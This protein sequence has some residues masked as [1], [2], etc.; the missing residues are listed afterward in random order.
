MEAQK[1]ALSNDVLSKIFNS[2][3]HPVAPKMYP[4]FQG[5]TVSPSYGCVLFAMSLNLHFL[6]AFRKHKVSCRNLVALTIAMVG[7]GLH[8][9]NAVVTLRPEYLS[10]FR[11]LQGLNPIPSGPYNNSK[12]EVYLWRNKFYVHSAARI[13]QNG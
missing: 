8:T 4:A 5:T 11:T 1:Q 10:V 13:P 12:N 9:L 3:Y 2:V 7:K 6:G